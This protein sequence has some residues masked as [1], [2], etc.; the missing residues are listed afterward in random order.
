MFFGGIVSLFF[1]IYAYNSSAG[2]AADA[3]NTRIFRAARPDARAYLKASLTAIIAAT[4]LLG[5]LDIRLAGAG[6]VS[7]GLW[8]LYSHP[9]IGLKRRRGAGTAAHL[10]GEVLHFAMGS[11]ALGLADFVTLCIGLYFGI[12]FSAGH[13]F[14]EVIDVEAD[15][16]AGVETAAVFFGT[17]TILRAAHSTFLLAACFL[18]AMWRIGI[19]Q[20]ALAG[21]FVVAAMFH[22]LLVVVVR[23]RDR[24]ALMAMRSRYR[25]CYLAAGLVFTALTIASGSGASL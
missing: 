23:D 17:R 1:S 9:S 11:L 18:L 13:L 19:A 22:V 6:L 25:I 12:L 16:N 20:V 2:Y 7:F 4:A 15:R 5:A 24:G 8:T 21:P 3:M 14:H 10:L